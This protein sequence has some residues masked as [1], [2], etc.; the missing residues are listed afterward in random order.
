MLNRGLIRFGLV[1]EFVAEL[2]YFMLILCP[3]FFGFISI[4]LITLTYLP[5][6]VMMYLGFN[7]YSHSLSTGSI[8]AVL[9]MLSP[10]LVL[11]IHITPMPYLVAMVGMGVAFLGDI[12]ISLFFWRAVKQGLLA[13]CWWP[14][15]RFFGP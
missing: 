10:L 8:G 3:R 9:L 14:R 15:D 5:S 4:L 6:S 11:I 2:L 12:S 7:G 13:S 1:L